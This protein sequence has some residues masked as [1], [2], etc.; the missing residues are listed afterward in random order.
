MLR[1][2]CDNDEEAVVTPSAVPQSSAT[3]RRLAELKIDKIYVSPL[4]RA[5]Q[6]ADAIAAVL[7]LEPFEQQWLLEVNHGDV[8][9]MDRTEADLAFPGL[10]DKWH[11]EPHAVSQIQSVSDSKSQW[12]ASGRRWSFTRCGSAL[13]QG[14]AIE[15][16]LQKADGPRSR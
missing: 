7:G 16:A 10:F 4:T 14:S 2:S 1:E 3:L 15:Y 6:S 12:L 5:R 9:G 13:T 11:T 8:E